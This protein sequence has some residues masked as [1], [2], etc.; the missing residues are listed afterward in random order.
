[1]K[2]IKEDL[3]EVKNEEMKWRGRAGRIERERER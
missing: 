3:N 1:M 2:K